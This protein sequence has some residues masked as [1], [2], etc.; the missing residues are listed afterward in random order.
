[1]RVHLVLLVANT[2]SSICAVQSRTTSNS[3]ANPLAPRCRTVAPR[4]RRSRAASVGTN[5]P[6]GEGTNSGSRPI[7]PAST[8]SGMSATQAPFPDQEVEAAQHHRP[9]WIVVAIFVVVFLAVVVGIFVVGSS[10]SGLTQGQVREL[11]NIRSSCTQWAGAAADQSGPPDAWCTDMVG[12]M[13]DRAGDHPGKWAS[14]SAM[15][16]TCEQWAASSPSGSGSESSRT[17]LCDVM[18]SWMQGHESEPGS[19]KNSMM[20]GSMMG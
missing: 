2:T 18:V 8:M 11:G 3:P 9:K 5:V 17:Q 20:S 12:W 15:R 4:S 1:M 7:R 6:I 14:P 10:G 16:S 13:S 19:W